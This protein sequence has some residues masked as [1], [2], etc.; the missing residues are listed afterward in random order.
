MS[1][2]SKET[3][4]FSS[5]KEEAIPFTGIST[6][7]KYQRF[8]DTPTLRRTYVVRYARTL[9]FQI[10]YYRK[11]GKV[12]RSLPSKL[13]EIAVSLTFIPKRNNFAKI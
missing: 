13:F 3:V 4:A 6:T 2:S 5:V 12:K 9:A 8:P 1:G 10:F 7:A 11:V